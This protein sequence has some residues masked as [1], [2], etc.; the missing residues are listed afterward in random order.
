MVDLLRRISQ[1]NRVIYSFIIF[2]ALLISSGLLGWQQATHLASQLPAPAAQAATAQA[3]LLLSGTCIVAAISLGIGFLVRKSIIAP[4]EDT[5]Q[6]VM[7]IASGDLETSIDSPCSDELSWLRHELNTMRKKLHGMVSEVRLS[8]EGVDSAS[9]EIAKGNSNLSERTENQ[10]SAIE[11][12]SVTMSSLAESVT[13]HASSAKDANH[14]M[15]EASDVATRGGEYMKDVIAQM[16]DIKESASKISEI[17][18]VID[19]IAF[20]TN[21]LALNAAVEAARAGDQGK[22]FAVVATEVRALA[23]RSA[24]AA[25]EIKTL[26][27]QSSNRVESG[28]QLVNEAGDTMHDLLTRVTK[29]ADLITNMAENGESQRH[30]I[31]EAKRAIALIDDATRQNSALVEEVTATAQT[32]RSQSGNLTKTVS[33]FHLNTPQKAASNNSNALST[34]Q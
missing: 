3:T 19:S 4:V 16:Q 6:A 13:E 32:L 33:I 5:V 2:A 17:I 29:V 1:A 20:Q 24:N 8:V 18:T 9:D 10:A 21:I 23:L 14:E 34:Q 30:A 15:R 31:E 12:T 7:R 22:G 26:I 28:S 25:S 11:E 27:A